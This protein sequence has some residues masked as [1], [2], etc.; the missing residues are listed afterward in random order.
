M[1][2]NTHP[3]THTTA[4]IQTMMRAS[5]NADAVTPWMDEHNNQHRPQ[6]PQWGERNL[7]M[8]DKRQQPCKNTKVQQAPM[9]P[10]T[11]YNA[12]KTAHTKQQGWGQQDSE[13]CRAPSKAAQAADRNSRR[14]SNSRGHMQG[15]QLAPQKQLLRLHAKSPSTELPHIAVTSLADTHACMHTTARFTHA[16]RATSKAAN[17]CMEGSRREAATPRGGLQEAWGGWSACTPHHHND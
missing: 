2:N 17:K 10:Q 1:Y 16:C 13:Q 8:L 9:R 12:R 7:I 14:R 4:P 15:R 3:G 11:R 5:L 6:H